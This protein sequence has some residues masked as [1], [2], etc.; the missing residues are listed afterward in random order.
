MKQERIEEFTLDGKNFIYIDLAGIKVNEEFAEFIAVV[1][2]AIEKYPKGSLYTITNIDGIRFDTE[3]KE[4]AAQYMEFNK[5]YVKHGAV[6]GLDGIKK[7]FIQTITKLSGRDD[8]LFAFSREQ[9]IELL[10]QQE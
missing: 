3:S 8:M 9:A 1:E 4:L 10:L 2:A 5:P 6:V 7:L